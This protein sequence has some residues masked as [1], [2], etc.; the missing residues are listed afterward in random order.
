MMPSPRVI[1]GCAPLSVAMKRA[2]VKGCPLRS[3]SPPRAL[4]DKGI[5]LRAFA[6]DG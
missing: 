3:N 4:S 5:S 6:L 1:G 2:P